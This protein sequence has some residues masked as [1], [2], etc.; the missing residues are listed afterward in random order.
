MMAE[1]MFSP[2]I[3]SSVVQN[4]GSTKVP[5][6]EFLV[7]FLLLCVGSFFSSDHGGNLSQVERVSHRIRLG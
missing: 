2:K 7:R 3:H 5:E 4:L 6:N 1:H